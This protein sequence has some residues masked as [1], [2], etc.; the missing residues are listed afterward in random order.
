M[1]CFNNLRPPRTAFWALARSP[2]SPQVAQAQAQDTVFWNSAQIQTMF[3]QLWAQP[4]GSLGL[5]LP[6][7]APA[8][9]LYPCSASSATPGAGSLVLGF[10]LFFFA[11]SIVSSLRIP[12][13]ANWSKSAR[14]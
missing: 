11:V 9:L 7:P 5:Q 12:A 1:I 3:L 8:Q 14:H 6:T 4:G 10:N 13:F 2:P